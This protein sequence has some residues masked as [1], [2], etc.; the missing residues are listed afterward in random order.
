MASG[1]L[2]GTRIVEL[3]AIGPAPYGV[4]LLAD[5][6]ADVIRVDRV[7]AAQGQLGAEASMIGLSRNRRSIG[8]DL[9]SPAGVEVVRRLTA[10]SDVLVEGFRP[11]VTER[12]GVGPDDLR[13]HNPALIYARMTGWGQDGPLAHRAGHDIDYAA[14]AG[15][16]H[17]V[18]RPDEPPTPPVNYLADFGGGG[19]FLAIGILAALLER[20][21]SGQ[22]QVVDAAMIDGTA[23]LT[24]FLHGLLQMGA[25]S[26]D[27]GTNLLDGGAPFYDSYRCADGGFVA[28]GAL[29]PPFYAALLEG[30]GLDAGEWP[31]YDRARWPALRTRLSEVFATRTRDQWAAAFDGTD[32]CVAPIL[33]LEEAPDHPH[34]QQRETFSEAF[35]TRQPAPAPR[36]SRTPGAIDRPP[37]GPGEHTDQVL[38]DL[39]YGSDEVAR[40]RADGVVA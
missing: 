20:S 1:P 25:W 9:K 32:A 6:G 30:L 8:V 18:G 10:R 11:G 39:G 19:T 5:L 17:T 26:T 36:F 13:A 35:G 21:T 16:L 12:L 23:S 14:I 31:Q 33:D 3:A 34:N 15:A 38:A 2:V 24:A 27:R 7:A 40:L 28:V 37:P 22:G 29:E 4:M